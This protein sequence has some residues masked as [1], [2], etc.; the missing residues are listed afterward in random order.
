MVSLINA[1]Q[2]WEGGDV[3]HFAA[4]RL[5]TFL[6]RPL[7]YGVCILVYIHAQSVHETPTLKDKARR[8]VAENMC[9]S[10]Y[11]ALSMELGFLCLFSLLTQAIGQA[12]K[13]AHL[14]LK[15]VSLLMTRYVMMSRV[16]SERST[17]AS[18]KLSM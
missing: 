4:C 12:D 15:V 3:K 11:T 10:K 14:C 2:G 7:A 5:L 6:M 18:V 17:I 1:A 8:F 9:L 16:R 13:P